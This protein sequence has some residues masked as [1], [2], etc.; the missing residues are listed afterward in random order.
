MIDLSFVY[1]HDF[2]YKGQFYNNDHPDYYRDLP[3]T[4]ELADDA[5]SYSLTSEGF[6]GD[7]FTE[8][9]TYPVVFM[10]CSNTF[11]LGLPEEAMWS[12]QIVQRIKRDTGGK[13]P[14]WNLA[15]NGSSIDV[16]FLFLEKYVHTLKPRAIFFLVPALFRRL[17]YFNGNTFITNFAHN[18]ELTAD[19]SIYPKAVLD[20][21]ALNVDESY[22]LFEAHKYMMAINGLCKL[23]NTKLYYQFCNFLTDNEQTF[24]KMKSPMYDNF[25][26]LSAPWPR[27]IDRARDRMHH[28]PKSNEIFANTVWDEVREDFQ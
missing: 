26:K 9:S 27:P 21:T 18:G 12:Y 28:G 2:G 14:H 11:G 6:R 20:A 1:R 5:F 3:Y 10:G 25:K 4:S 24:F 17:I 23:Y 16:Q 19:H 8:E 13:V 22:S 7:E 15:K